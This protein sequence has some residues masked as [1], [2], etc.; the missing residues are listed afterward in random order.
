MDIQLNANSVAELLGRNGAG[1][2]R[3]RSEAH[4][5]SGELRKEAEARA[6]PG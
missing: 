4:A 3:R 5:E 1:A 6:E 2:K